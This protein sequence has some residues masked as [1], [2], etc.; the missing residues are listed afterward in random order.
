MS[1]GDTHG[2]Q[3]DRPKSEG[4]LDDNPEGGVDEK[5]EIGSLSAS[6]LAQAEMINLLSMPKVEIDKFDGDP[7]EYQSF[8]TICNS[9]MAG[10]G[11]V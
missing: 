2:F 4:R 1:G 7:L 5:S 6:T 3:E 8:I 11:R 10:G 9:K